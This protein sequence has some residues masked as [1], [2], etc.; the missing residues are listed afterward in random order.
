MPVTNVKSR[1]NSGN[2]LFSN[3][4]AAPG[5]EYAIRGR[6]TVAQ[7]NAGATILPAIPGISYRVVDVS[8]IAVGGAAATATSVDILATQATASVKI[9]ANAVAGLTQSAVLRAGAT[10]SVV[11]T[12]GASFAVNDVNTAITILKAGADVATATHIDVHLRYT[13][14]A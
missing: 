12:D 10:N 5:I 11:L 9:V 1:W 3:A 13:M 14:E 6:F 7:V 4:A 8:M 2:L